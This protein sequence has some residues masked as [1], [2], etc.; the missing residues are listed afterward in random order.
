MKRAKVDKTRVL[1]LGLGAFGRLRA[2]RVG[3][4]RLRVYRRELFV[5]SRRRSDGMRRETR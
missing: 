3:V 5:A 2:R 4:C 1:C